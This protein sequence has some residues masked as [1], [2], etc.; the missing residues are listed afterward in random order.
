[1]THNLGPTSISHDLRPVPGPVTLTCDPPRSELTEEWAW[2]AREEAPTPAQLEPAA[3]RIAAR[4]ERPPHL[5][6]FA[7]GL[8]QVVSVEGGV[9]ERL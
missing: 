1:M 6:A 3:R 8:S 5:I 2:L 7:H 4:S 9:A